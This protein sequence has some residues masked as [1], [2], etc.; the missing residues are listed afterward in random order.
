MSEKLTFT[1]DGITYRCEKGMTILEAARENGVYIPSLCNIPGVTPRSSCRM[2][3][4]KVND[5]PM[6]ACTTIIFDGMEVE[7]DIP[8]L[9]EFRKVII[10]ALFVEGNH[11]CPF[12][13]KSGN[14]MLQA[15]AYRFK[16]MAPRF[17]YTF[18]VK[19]IDATHP[20]L[21]LD[22]SRCILCKRCVR[23]IKDDKGR[24]LFAFY[25]R[26]HKLRIHLDPLLAHELTDEQAQQAMD[27]C[28]VGT[29][30][31]REKGFRIPIGKRTYDM[32]PI[33]SDI[34]RTKQNG[35]D[36]S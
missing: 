29:I 28:P 34:E 7:N 32:M 4:V 1:I 23:A 12:C 8:E 18:P 5:R 2:C 36:E 6:S 21:I 20:K 19:E 17:P 14:C 10:E 24:S 9:N 13:E 11:F 25:R 31:V 26:G 30:L 15:L 3:T 35:R 33:G 27:V 22:H 16:M